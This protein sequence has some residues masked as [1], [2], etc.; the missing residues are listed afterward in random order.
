LGETLGRMAACL[1]C[2]KFYTCTD[3]SPPCSSPFLQAW[4]SYMDLN[5]HKGHSNRA[6][7]GLGGSG[8]QRGG[9]YIVLRRSRFR[10]A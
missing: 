8:W 6:A 7:E 1:Q 9:V 5:K 10:V 4:A 3:L 2:V